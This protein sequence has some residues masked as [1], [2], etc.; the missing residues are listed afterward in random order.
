MN[1]KKEIKKAERDRKK[2]R[3]K[4]KR[5]IIENKEKSIHKT[6]SRQIKGQ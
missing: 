2:Y 5:K 6:K 3:I 1:N 4:E